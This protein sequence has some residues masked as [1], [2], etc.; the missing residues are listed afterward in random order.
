MAIKSL[1]D[2]IDRD[3]DLF[4]AGV[5]PTEMKDKRQH[6]GELY[7][8]ADVVKPANGSKCKHNRFY[9]PGFPDCKISR[10]CVR[11][12]H[13]REGGNPE[14]TGCR[15]K[16]GMTGAGHLFEWKCLACVFR[17]HKISGNA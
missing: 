16:S 8:D 11:R 1:R 2:F 7:K 13:S 10:L 3:A 15:I 14:Y 12:C 4:G 6:T 9:T 17:L 5:R